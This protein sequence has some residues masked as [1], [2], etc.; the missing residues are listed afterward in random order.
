MAQLPTTEINTKLH[1]PITK[2][3]TR[4]L[5]RITRL[6]NTAKHMLP[7]SKTNKPSI[8]D[9]QHTRRTQT[10]ATEVLQHIDSPKLEVIPSLCNKAI[11]TIV[12]KA[13]RKLVD[14]LQKKEDLLYKKSPERYH[15]SLK[16][17]CLYVC[18][19]VYARV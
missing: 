12:N 9:P 8:T 1:P 13:N 6:R 15:Y 14:S 2:L 7:N 17:A 18:V 4:H 11:G 3:D 16:T 19:S 5:K 10:Q